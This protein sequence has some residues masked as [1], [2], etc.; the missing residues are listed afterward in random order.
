MCRD[1][2]GLKKDSIFARKEQKPPALASPGL[3]IVFQSA[4]LNSLK[5]KYW[6]SVFHLWV[7]WVRM[8]WVWCGHS[9][10]FVLRSCLF[11]VDP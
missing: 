8:A 7:V 4:F 10:P 2:W 9:G 1:I 5:L 6:T 3:E 11:Y